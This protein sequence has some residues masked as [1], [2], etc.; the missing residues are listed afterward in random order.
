M[1]LTGLPPFWDLSTLRLI[2]EISR[3]A[4]G[5]LEGQTRAPGKPAAPFSGLLELLRAIED[6]LLGAEQDDP[7]P[8]PAQPTNEVKK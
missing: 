6:A 5:H 1:S 7:G 3:S 4:D 2:V 8:S